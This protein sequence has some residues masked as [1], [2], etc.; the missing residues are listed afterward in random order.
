[1]MMMGLH[2][3]EE[4]PF[5][6]VY[7]HALVRDEK[8]AEDVEV[9]GQRHRPA[10]PHRRPT[11][12]TRCASRSP[13]WPRR[14]ATSSCRPQPRRGLPQFRD[15][16]WN[17]AR[18]A[19]MNEC[20]RAAR[21]RS[22][23]RQADGQPLDRRRDRARGRRRHRSASRPT[24]FNE[25]AA[26]ST[27]SSWDVFCDWY[28]EL[29]KPIAPGRRRRGQG[30]DARDGRLGARP[31]PEAAAS[32]HALHHRGAVGAHGRARRAAREPAGAR[33]SGR[34]CRGLTDAAAEDEIGWVIESRDRD[35]LRAHRDERS[36]GG[37]DPARASGRGRR[38]EQSARSS[39]R[40]RSAG[41]HAWK[42]S[43]SP[44]RRPR[45]RR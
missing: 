18:F 40:T 16:A 27:S 31:D 1:M 23:R 29:I 42:A 9:E 17:A 5:R 2:F 20:V 21:L 28:L 22:G 45:G 8:G 13:P 14:G 38:L 39:T 24:S 6:D 4:V 26:P 33:A 34:S 41:S 7:I 19:E 3:M 36:G 44:R 43:P 25:A 37:Q 10:R 35:P 12:P 30:R 32:V 11:A 15:Q